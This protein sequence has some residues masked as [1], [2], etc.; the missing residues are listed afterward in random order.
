MRHAELL[1][2]SEFWKN[3]NLDLPTAR[4]RVVIHSPYLHPRRV[5]DCSKLFSP[6]R[7]RGV[8]TCLTT[9]RPERVKLELLNS[10]G[11]PVS[12]NYSTSLELL[13]L[14]RTHLNQSKFHHKFVLI[15]DRI[16]YYGSM[17]I[18]SHFNTSECMRRTEDKEEIEEA[19]DKFNLKHCEVCMNDI[20]E[21]WGDSAQKE[22]VVKLGLLIKKQRTRL[23]LTLQDL[24]RLSGIPRQTISGM[25]LGENSRL[26]SYLT[27][28]EALNLRIALVPSD[29]E[30]AVLNVTRHYW[31][32]IPSLDTV[33]GRKP[34]KKSK[35]KTLDSIIIAPSANV[36]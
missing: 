35:S 12:D 17:N 11:D 4:S 18:F 29:V 33:K 27:V 24:A 15:D 16:L 26:S 2:A 34:S 13:S 3:F 14:W 23:D 7:E 21:L 28:L 22:H 5:S 1:T 32:E 31:N 8:V 36:V 25:E 9:Q 30:P 10:E 19:I 6:L 20:I